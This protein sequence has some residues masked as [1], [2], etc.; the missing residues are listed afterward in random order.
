MNA[1]NTESTV[2]K[3]NEKHTPLSITAFIVSLLATLAS[4]RALLYINYGVKNELEARIY[5]VSTAISL[6]LPFVT[7]GLGMW[8]LSRKGGN[9]ILATIAIGISLAILSSVGC[10]VLLSAMFS[11]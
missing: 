9:T 5:A 8:A 11:P 1:E 6:I 10:G 4:V 2:S 7:I 3:T